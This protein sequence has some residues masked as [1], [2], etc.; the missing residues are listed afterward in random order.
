MATKKVY[1]GSEKKK[2]APKKTAKKAG[3][4]RKYTPRK[5]K[6][7]EVNLVQVWV[8]EGLVFDVGLLVGRTISQQARA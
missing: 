5:K 7:I 3:A 2:S 6:H 1:F 4:K 8:P